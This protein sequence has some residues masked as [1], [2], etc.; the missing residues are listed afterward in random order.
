VLGPLI[1]A[2]DNLPNPPP[3]KNVNFKRRDASVNYNL[4]ASSNLRK[5]VAKKDDDI[6]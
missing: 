4:T 5:E 3:D 1:S 6:P 2:W